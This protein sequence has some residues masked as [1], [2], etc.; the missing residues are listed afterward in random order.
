MSQAFLVEAALSGARVISDDPFIVFSVY[1]E[2]S[3]LLQWHEA[4][5][6]G[7]LTV[8]SFKAAWVVWENPAV[9]P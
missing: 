9:A 6:P 4:T 8:H 2:Y 3:R 1:F 7:F 5:L